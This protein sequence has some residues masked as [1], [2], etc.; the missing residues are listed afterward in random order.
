MAPR[1]AKPASA[2]G[3]SDNLSKSRTFFPFNQHTT[4]AALLFE[5]ERLRNPAIDAKVRIQCGK[6]DRTETGHEVFELQLDHH[7]TITGVDA[8]VTR[9]PTFKTPNDHRDFQKIDGVDTKVTLNFHKRNGGPHPVADGFVFENGHF[10]QLYYYDR[11]A[12]IRVYRL[13]DATGQRVLHT[14]VRANHRRQ[15]QV[16]LPA[17]SERR[18]TPTK[19]DSKGRKK[20]IPGSYYSDEFTLIEDIGENEIPVGAPRNDMDLAEYNRRLQVAESRKVAFHSIWPS[21]QANAAA[22][23]QPHPPPAPPVPPLVALAQQLVQH[24]QAI[25]AEAAAQAAAAAPASAAPVQDVAAE[26]E[27]SAATVSA[28]SSAPVP[29]TRRSR[30]QKR[31]EEPDT[32]GGPAHSAAKAQR[33]RTNSARP[34]RVRRSDRVAAEEAAG[35]AM[36]GLHVPGSAPAPASGLATTAPSADAAPA[37]LRDASEAQSEQFA[38]ATRTGTAVQ[39]AYDARAVH[40]P[41]LTSTSALYGALTPNDKLAGAGNI[42]AGA[43]TLQKATPEA[44]HFSR[45]CTLGNEDLLHMFARERGCPWASRQDE[46]EE[47]AL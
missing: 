47:G 4:S 6:G 15:W 27:R 37:E 3:N 22:D 33:A 34:Y 11:S 36:D 46:E 38:N 28:P 40:A 17:P 16:L 10:R 5:A 43:Q 19:V 26:A 45:F 12:F 7:M 29:Q 1:K 30:K 13:D 32:E 25:R 24:A 39:L 44:V 9:P 14:L 21:A 23:P 41:Y 31:E 2:P 20:I 35:G 42:A 18:P 8:S